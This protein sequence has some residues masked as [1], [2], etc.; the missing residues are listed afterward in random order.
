MP[1]LPAGCQVDTASLRLFV[2]SHVN[3]RTLQAHR[4]TGSWTES[5]VTWN[6]RP[7]LGGTPATTTSGSGW[8][9]WNVANLVQESYDASQQQGF[10][11][12]DAVISGGGSAVQSFNSR[13]HNQ[14]HPAARVDLQS[15]RL[16][17]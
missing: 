16:T 4:V 1:T 12:R 5:A 6:N 11:V 8:R 3:N 7:S 9:E 10:L 15:V 17:G 2:S 13:E 14:S